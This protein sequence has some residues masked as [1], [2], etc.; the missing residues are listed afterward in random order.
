LTR[1]FVERRLKDE[2]TEILQGLRRRL[3]SGEPPPAGLG[4]T[5]LA[6]HTR[7]LTT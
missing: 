7:L 4:A 5:S 6:M 1:W 2:A 3:E